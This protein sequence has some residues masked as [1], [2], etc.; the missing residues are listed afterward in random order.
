T[1]GD[2]PRAQF[3]RAR[4]LLMAA[5]SQPGQRGAYQSEAS[6]LLAQLQAAGGPW[7]SRAAQIVRNGLDNP[8]NW[9]G[10][11]AKDVPPPPAEWD[12]T[13]QLVAAGKFKEA[14]P[15]LEKVLASTD[16]EEKKNKD[17]ARYLLG[18]ARYRSGDLPGAM[19]I[20]DQVLAEKGA[21]KYRDDAGYLRFKA[22]EAPYAVD[23]RAANE[24]IYAQA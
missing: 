5:A 14:I 22:T 23:P 6:S 10:P 7:G 12:V 11:K 8:K 16:E 2:Q 21:T 18:L 24:P 17:E 15:R 20:F 4:A 3:T 1:A 19:T 13:K 9:A